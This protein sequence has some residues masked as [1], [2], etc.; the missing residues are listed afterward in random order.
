MAVKSRTRSAVTRESVRGQVVRCLRQR[1]LSD[2]LSSHIPLP[3]I[4]ALARRENVSQATIQQAY[5]QL[6][7]EGLV[8][9]RPRIGRFAAT[10]SVRQK[11]R[12]TLDA[13]RE[14]LRR[15]VA[16][17]LDSGLSRTLIRTEF[18]RL[19]NSGPLRR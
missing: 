3:T 18:L 5:R 11:Q 8:E 1:L 4:R 12:K 6:E 14:D 19:L 7:A 9:S 15:P 13:L 10:L 17:A 2:S 16:D